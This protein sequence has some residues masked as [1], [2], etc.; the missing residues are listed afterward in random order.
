MSQHMDVMVDLSM[1]LMAIGFLF[2]LAVY[3][4]YKIGKR[5]EGVVIEA[6][7]NSQASHAEAMKAHQQRHAEQI[8]ELQAL[9]RAQAEFIVTKHPL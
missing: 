7:V 5:R 9:V 1:L 6:L 3:V 2:G 8:K 4:G